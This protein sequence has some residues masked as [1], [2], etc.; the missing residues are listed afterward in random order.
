MA[1]KTEQRLAR[2]I[3][4]HFELLAP[5]TPTKRK[6]GVNDTEQGFIEGWQRKAVDVEQHLKDHA[7]ADLDLS[8]DTSVMQYKRS[9][10]A[11]KK[12]FLSELKGYNQSWLKDHG[13]YH[14]VN[15]IIKHFRETLNL[16]FSA[17]QDD[18]NTEYRNR[19]ETRSDDSN[20]IECDLTEYLKKAQQTLTL[21]SQDA[22][23]KEVNWRD[24]SCA[25][26]LVTGRR[27]SE[28]HW[29]ATFT[30]VS[31]YEAVFTGQLKGKTRKAK[32]TD[33]DVFDHKFTIPT[34]LN[35][36]LAIAGLT[37]LDNQG[38]RLDRKTGNATQV[39]K[40]WGKYC[41]SQV[42]EVWCIIPDE[43][44]KETDPQD[45]WTYHK[46][47]GLYFIACLTN[48]GENRSFSSLKRYA[49]QIL[50]D[51]DIKAIEPY[52]RIDIKNGSTTK[53]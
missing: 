9:A 20:R 50:C 36:D 37:W 30:R 47:R 35:V 28:I 38:K 14:P 1:T 11:A 51:S 29:S 43:I 42:R 10:V 41:S 33:T 22:D 25:L 26:A 16:L 44:W 45:K 2:E 6:K 31:D 8:D 23:S 12:R 4:E 46:L 17:F 39:N 53:I 24:V 40:K 18:I 21:C 48:L 34:L 32:G 7:K 5:Y 13:N 27:Q 15:T 3:V 52:E 49:P 19:V